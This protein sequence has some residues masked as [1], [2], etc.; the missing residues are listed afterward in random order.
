VARKLIGMMRVHRTN[1]D[2]AAGTIV[3]T[4]A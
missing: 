1:E 4:E 2:T 3:E